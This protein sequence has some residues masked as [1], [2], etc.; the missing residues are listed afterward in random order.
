MGKAK[1]EEAKKCRDNKFKGIY[2]DSRKDKTL[3]STK[4]LVSVQY[5]QLIL[6]DPDKRSHHWPLSPQ[7]K[8]GIPHHCDQ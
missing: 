3:V 8:E 7:T 2:F 4:K 6:S 1:E 5:S